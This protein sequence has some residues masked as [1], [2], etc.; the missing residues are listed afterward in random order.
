MPGSTSPNP[1]AQQLLDEVEIDVISQIAFVTS[2]RRRGAVE[3]LPHPPQR[4]SG[5][6]AYLQCKTMNEPSV[7][8]HKWTE[9][10]A[11]AVT[12]QVLID[13]ACSVVSAATSRAAWVDITRRRGLELLDNQ[14]ASYI[15][16]ERPP[17]IANKENPEVKGAQEYALAEWDFGISTLCNH[18]ALHTDHLEEFEHGRFSSPSYGRFLESADH[19]PSDQSENGRIRRS[20]FPGGS[21]LEIGNLVSLLPQPHFHGVPTSAPYHIR[22]VIS[23]PPYRKAYP[24]AVAPYTE[25]TIR[26]LFGKRFIRLAWIVPIRGILPWPGCTS[27]CLLSPE[28]AESFHPF[29]PSGPSHPTGNTAHPRSELTWTRGSVMAFW[30][31]LL[32]LRRVKSMGPLSLSF[33]P[34]FKS[35]TGSL[36]GHGQQPSSESHQPTS[37]APAPVMSSGLLSVDHIK[38]FHDSAYT[39]QLRNIID[40]W[41]FQPGAPREILEAMSADVRVPRAPED[42]GMFQTGDL[43]KVR[44]F[45]GAKLVL[46]DEKSRAAMVL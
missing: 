18:E 24:T 9:D 44:M 7:V 38:I 23:F 21:E 41:A 4:G 5:T 27:G 37:G 22:E 25:E 6:A 16:S 30:D 42:R 35:D 13:T 20:E 34:V 17:A 26:L 15:Y 1:R 14:G 28:L 19:S 3:P 31:F 8:V 33:H 39:L 10:E 36:A 40:V 43:M 2:Q 32:E 45:V 11:A 29:L 46:L 12:P